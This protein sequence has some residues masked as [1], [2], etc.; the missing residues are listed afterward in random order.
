MSD[1]Y[2]EKNI[3][4]VNQPEDL[5]DYIRVTTPSVWI[6]LIAIALILVAILGWMVFGGGTRRQRKRYRGASN[7][8]CDQLRET[9][10]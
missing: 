4:R 9:H 8:L 6:V 10:S 5:N 1:I 7:H 3:N 2:R